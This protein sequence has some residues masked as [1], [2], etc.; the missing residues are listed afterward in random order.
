MADGSMSRVTIFEVAD[1]AGVS[2]GT[3]SKALNGRGQLRA[4]TVERVRAAA[5][6]LGFEPSELAKSLLRGRTF[7]VGLL[8]SDSFGRF[9]IPLT[10]GIEDALGAGQISVFLCD[11][12]GDRVREQHYV[13]S[14]LSR[15]VD[16]II[17]TGRRTDPRAPIN[18]ERLP[19]P[20]VY[21][22]CQSSSPDDLSLLPDDYQGGQLAARHL[23]ARGRRRLAHV[24]GPVRFAAVREREQGLRSVLDTAGVE[25][26]ASRI[27]AGEWTEAWGREAAGALLSQNPDV[28]AIFCGSDIIARGVAD[29][30]REA[31]IRVPEDVALVGFDNWEIMAAATRPPL[32]SID[33][34]IEGLGKTAAHR[35]LAMIRGDAL[36]GVERMPCRLVVRDSS[37][38]STL[39][40]L[41]TEHD[42]SA[43]L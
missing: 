42:P 26:P 21:A 36:S 16:G 15:R 18:D 38:V 17:V 33:M 32:T 3:V 5:R 41:S 23:L 13:R 9:S 6:D 20:V 37:G 25:L 2:V 7:T 31:G 24:T 29:E 14:L 10:S 19:V 30:L 4:E 27:L 11:A 34:N 39:R 43:S 12:R 8:T 40:D 1:L 22:Y 35:L 28:D